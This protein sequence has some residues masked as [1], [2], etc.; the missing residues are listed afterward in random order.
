MPVSATPIDPF[1]GGIVLGAGECRH[2]AR[3]LEHVTRQLAQAVGEC[4]RTL[5]MMKQWNRVRDESLTSFAQS[6]RRT[7]MKRPAESCS[8]TSDGEVTPSASNI[9]MRVRYRTHG[10]SVLLHE[11]VTSFLRQ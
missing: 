8:V 2:A 9:P 1:R 4:V 5:L 7:G 3:V 11:T 10:A 6:S